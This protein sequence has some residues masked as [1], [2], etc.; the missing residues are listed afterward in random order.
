M[1]ALAEG[2]MA[3]LRAEADRLERELT[4]LLLPKDPMDEKNIM[5]E[6]RAGS[7]PHL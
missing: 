1:V 6:I 2:E 3:T 4:V 7:P 5:L